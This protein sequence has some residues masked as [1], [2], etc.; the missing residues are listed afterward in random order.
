M[1]LPSL[2]ALRAFEAVGRTGS[3][4]AAGEELAISPTVVSRHIQNLQADLGVTL[5]E[6]KGRGVI[7]TQAGAQY[8]GQVRQAFDLLRQATQGTKT[9][10]RKSLTIWCIPG[11]AT[12]K[13]LARLPELEA[14]LGGG[15]IPLQPPLSRPD[16]SRGDADAEIVYLDNPPRQG[17]LRAERLSHP[18][19]FP[20]AS[21]ALLARFP[22]ITSPLDLLRLPL[23]HED[24]TDQWEFWLRHA[25]VTHIPILQGPRL[26]HA[27]LAI[28]A[29]KIGQGIAIANALLVEDDVRLG[30]LV[31]VLPSE[32]YLGSYYL[33]APRNRWSSRPIQMLFDWLVQVLQPGRTMIA[34]SGAA[35]MTKEADC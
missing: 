25:G 9:T 30:R 22:D 18:R 26:W 5:M 23:I 15:D 3:I 24:S 33:V 4:R 31:E 7:L 2:A 32:V 14:Q 8:H 19:V 6:H 27:H 21:P 34:A 29:A 20:V 35:I 16:F 17:D 1:R 12:V 28:E 11:L 13:L 10:G